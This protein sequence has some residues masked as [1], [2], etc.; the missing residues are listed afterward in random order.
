MEENLV[1][2]DERGDKVIFERVFRLTK[3][4]VNKQ[5]LYPRVANSTGVAGEIN[6]LGEIVDA[7][8]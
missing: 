1:V 2:V 7:S 6:A 5:S 4:P 8:Q 3:I